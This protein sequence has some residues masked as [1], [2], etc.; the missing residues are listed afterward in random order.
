MVTYEEA[1]VHLGID[2]PD[3]STKKIV[4]QKLAAAIK[5]LR[6]AVGEDVETLMPNDERAKELV[7]T[8]LDDLYTNRGTSAKVSGAVRRSVQAMELQLQLELRRLRAREVSSV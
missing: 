7:I 4:T 6:G 8:Y 2:Y 3:E 5:T 1:L